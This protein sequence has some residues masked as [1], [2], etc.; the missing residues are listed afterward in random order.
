MSGMEVAMMVA[1]TV[2]SASAKVIAG[3]SAMQTAN[4]Q[5][6]L[7]KRE[8]D[9]A[10]QKS[11]NDQEGIISESDLAIGQAR[12]NAGAYGL[13][14][15]GSAND[16][17]QRLAA[18]RSAAANSAVYE[19][20]NAKNNAYFEAKQIKQSGKNQFIGSMIGAVGDA[21]SGGANIASEL[22]AQKAASNAPMPTTLAGTTRSSTMQLGGQRNY[23]MFNRYH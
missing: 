15:S 8:G 16:I 5:A 14:A 13:D 21:I 22:K 4:A 3:Y 1:S 6:K 20:L 10:L 19:G 7:T 12:A 18:Q 9:L 11:M 2:A 17:I 23:G